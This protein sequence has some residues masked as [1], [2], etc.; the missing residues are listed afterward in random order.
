MRRTLKDG[1]IPNPE[2]LAQARDR[3]ERGKNIKAEQTH[4][5]LLASGPITPSMAPVVQQSVNRITS[6]KSGAP[7]QAENS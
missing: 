4:L 5:R 6:L 7:T 3:Y 2:G 1:P